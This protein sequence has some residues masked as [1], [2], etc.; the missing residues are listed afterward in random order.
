MKKKIR[1]VLA[2]IIFLIVGVEVRGAEEQYPFAIGNEEIGLVADIVKKV[3]TEKRDAALAQYELD[4]QQNLAQEPVAEKPQQAETEQVMMEDSPM[5]VVSENDGG[6]VNSEAIKTWG[7]FPEISIWFGG[8][9]NPEAETQG[10][11]L[12]AKWLEWFT[13]YEKPENFGIGAS[14]RADYGWLSDSKVDWGYVAPGPTVGYY[15]GLGLRDSFQTDISLLY[16]FDQNRDNGWMP[17]AHVEFDHIFDYKNRLIVQVD[18]VYFPGDSWL[19]PGIHW[20]HKLN[21]NWKITSGATASIG[22]LDGDVITGFMPDLMFKYNNRWSF[23]ISANLF[24]G[25]GT[26]YGFKAAYELKPDIDTW[27]QT[28][29]AAGVKTKKVSEEDILDEASGIEVS[30][31]TIDQ[32]I[33][34]EGS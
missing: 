16:R 3:R 34:E 22:W 28:K 23:G 26:F 17:T 33:E 20:E 5:M 6:S 21:K 32:L 11:W 31:K 24:T 14:L 18:G 2:L 4:G 12:V 7:S 15:R 1:V 9:F 27:W 8:W 25:L 29:N 10:V 30:K 19:G 13:T